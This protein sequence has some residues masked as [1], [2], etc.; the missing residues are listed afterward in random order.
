MG[1]GGDLLC[2]ISCSIFSQGIADA[3]RQTLLAFRNDF[4]AHVPC[5]IAPDCL[6][7]RALLINLLPHALILIPNYLD[8]HQPS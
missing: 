4:E 8:H 2:W 7:A 3:H 5:L 1:V 6:H